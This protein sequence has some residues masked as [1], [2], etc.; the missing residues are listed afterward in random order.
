MVILGPTAADAVFGVDV[1]FGVDGAAPLPGAAGGIVVQPDDKIVVA[2][3]AIGFMRVVRYEA[4]GTLDGGFG[5]GGSAFVDV[6]GDPT[7]DPFP[8]SAA[9]AQQADGKIVLGGSASLG[10]GQQRDAI[11]ARLNTDGTLDGTFGASGITRTGG[12]ADEWIAALVVQPDGKIVAAGGI[13]DVLLPDFWLARYDASGVLDPTFG[14]GGVVVTSTYAG[15]TDLLLQPDGKLIAVGGQFNNTAD[16]LLARYLPDGTLDGTFGVGG[17]AAIELPGTTAEALTA[18]LQP[19]GKIVLAGTFDVDFGVSDVLL[20]RL[21]ADGSLDTTFGSGGTVRTAIGGGGSS[22]SAVLLEPDGTIVAAGAAGRAIFVRRWEAN[23]AVDA[24]FAPC[25]QVVAPTGAIGES[26][27]EAVGLVRQSDGDLIALGRSNLLGLTD[28]AAPVCMSA[29][30]LQAN[31][32]SVAG[33]NVAKVV[34]RRTSAFD[35]LA[36]GDPTTTAT[37]FQLC[38]LDETTGV[39]RLR[40]TTAVFGGET[41]G[42][43]PCWKAT[44]NGFRYRRK[45]E[46]G[47]SRL[48]PGLA[49]KL[50]GT[51]SSGK[52]VLKANGGEYAVG[53]DAATPVVLPATVRLQRMDLGACWDGVFSTAIANDTDAFRA[54]SP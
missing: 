22:A 6:G 39:P 11:L 12:G 38:I 35:P 37:D 36:F 21:D 1:T 29:T 27:D 18:A 48:K 16:L 2:A 43:K 28:L 30:K 47:G 54:K 20:A 17:I 4:D 3:G 19:D 44:A 46:F 5:T 25:V 40:F 51:P 23:G 50:I 52:I 7:P 8:M 42:A 53:L 32:R 41:C 45:F 49:M 24:S 15:A 31:L 14:T 26:G 13:D 10:S 33:R 9:V 34:W